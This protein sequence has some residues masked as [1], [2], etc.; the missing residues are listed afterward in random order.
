LAS[1]LKNNCTL[2]S[3]PIDAL[4]L[5]LPPA[6]RHHVTEALKIN[7]GLGDGLSKQLLPRVIRKAFRQFAGVPMHP[8]RVD[9]DFVSSDDQEAQDAGMDT[10]MTSAL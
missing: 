4:V 3:L 7:V 9:D 1:C 5:A 6:E 8:V 2:A 10:S